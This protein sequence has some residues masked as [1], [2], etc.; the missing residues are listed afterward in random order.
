MHVD[1]PRSSRF[2]LKSR[3]SM[4]I[5]LPLFVFLAIMF[6][7][8]VYLNAVGWGYAGYGGYQNPA[9]PLYFN[10]PQTIHDRNIWYNRY[11]HY[12]YGHGK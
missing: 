9:F 2:C 12:G 11:R 5:A 7:G 1:G 10:S 3:G 6:S 4:L 8:F